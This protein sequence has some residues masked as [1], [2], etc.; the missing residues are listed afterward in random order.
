MGKQT[1]KVP[2]TRSQTK[3]QT[4]RQTKRRKFTKQSLKNP[5]CN[6]VY[7]AKPIYGGWVSFTAH[8][9]KKKDYPLFRISNKTESK[10]RDYGYL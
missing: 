8:L 1:L 10:T 7:M 6:L 2:R 3:T 9:A 5:K 4:K